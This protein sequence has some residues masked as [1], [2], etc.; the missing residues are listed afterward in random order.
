MPPT[1]DLAGHPG[2]C[3]DWESNRDLVVRRVPLNPQSHT[4]GFEFLKP[5]HSFTL[6]IKI[7]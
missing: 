6:V 4:A 2:T 1:E 3:P 5:P 7:I